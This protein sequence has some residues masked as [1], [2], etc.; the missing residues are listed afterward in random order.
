M[1]VEQAKV[2]AKN[3]ELR[4]AQ[5]VAEIVKPAQAEAERIRTLAKADADRTRMSAEAASAEGR[6]ALDQLIIS[7]LPQMI[8]AA[9]DGLSNANVTVLN[10][11]EGLNGTVAALASQGMAILRAVTD[12]L[13]SGSSY[14]ADDD[15]ARPTGRAAAARPRATAGSPASA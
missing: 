14:E 4:E 13:G 11:A 15:D 2:A 1:L 6:I 10:G 5:L 12:G 8:A 7:Q 9:A 3:A